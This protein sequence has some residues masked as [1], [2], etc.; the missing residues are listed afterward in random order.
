M[1]HMG[2]ASNVLKAVGG[3]V[4]LT[5]R[6]FPARYPATLP[7]SDG[8][9]EVPLARFSPAAIRT[10]M[11]IEE[12]AP[13]NAPPQPSR[14]HTIAQFYAAIERGLDQVS[15]KRNPFLDHSGQIL[16]N[17]Y[18]GTYGVLIP[19]DHR[20]TGLAKAQDALHQIVDQGEG[21]G[22]TFTSKGRKEVAHYYRF[23]EIKEGRLYAPKDKPKSRPSGPPLPVDW[24]AVYDMH[25]NPSVKHFKPGSEARRKM[26]DF[27]RTYMALLAGLERAINDDPAK[28]G[29]C[30]AGMYDLKY[31]AVELMKIPY[32]DVRDQTLP[33]APKTGTLGPSFEY[34][35]PD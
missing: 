35:R 18:Y 8:S 26:E 1:L 20:D 33:G 15:E 21:K 34:I 6:D 5:N 30:V 22:S 3:R 11:K 2:L 29:G 14:Y 13:P 28:I 23:K 7:H 4:K 24:H 25:P 17:Q 32:R 9:F 16:P 19:I 27:N 12:P 10:F 31:K